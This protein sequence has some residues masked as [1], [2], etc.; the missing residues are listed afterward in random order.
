LASQGLTVD[1]IAAELL[2]LMKNVN[3]PVLVTDS[4]PTTDHG[5]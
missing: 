3:P 5:S 4:C 1:N 2:N